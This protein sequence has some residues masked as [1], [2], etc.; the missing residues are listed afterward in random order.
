MPLYS[1]IRPIRALRAILREEVSPSRNILECYNTRSDGSAWLVRYIYPHDIHRN[2][3]NNWPEEFVRKLDSLWNNSRTLVKK[4]PDIYLVPYHPSMP[5]TEQD[6]VIIS[7]NHIL[8]V[9]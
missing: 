4:I 2:S 3:R 5:L 1:G 8:R 9:D 6:R 7:P